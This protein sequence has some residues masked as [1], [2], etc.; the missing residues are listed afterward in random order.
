VSG[1]APAAIART[2]I[3]L[4]SKRAGRALAGAAGHHA[5]TA[6][7]LVGA[8]FDSLDSGHGPRWLAWA[9]I[10]V[11]AALVVAVIREIRALRRHGVE[12]DSIPI[13]DY[14]A[15]PLLVLEAVHKHEQG[16]HLI[17][18]AYGFIALATLARALAWH[19]L[20]RI[21]RLRLDG[22][23]LDIRLRP[24]RRVRVAWADLVAVERVAQGLR[25]GV[26]GKDEQV[27]RL[28]DLLNRAEVEDAI[29]LDFRVRAGVRDEELSATA[30]SPATPPPSPG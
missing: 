11:G 10:V 8:G 15:V 30:P 7:L 12:P 1:T 2:E 4:R 18:W 16:L 3:V 26:R 25:L 28:G 29:L 27:L 23:G 17:P 20:A 22:V 13:V 5:T 6:A 24:F 14:L 9:S 19:R 21:L